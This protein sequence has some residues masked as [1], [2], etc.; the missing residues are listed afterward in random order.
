LLDWDNYSISGTEGENAYGG[1]NFFL[2]N[3][4]GANSPITGVGRSDFVAYL[5]PGCVL[6]DAWN[7]GYG[8][9]VSG[10]DSTVDAQNDFRVRFRIFDVAGGGY[11]AE[12]DSGQVCWSH[13]TLERFDVNDMVTVSTPYERTTLPDATSATP[14][15]A[16]ANDGFNARSVLSATTV[17]YGD[18]MELTPTAAGGWGL[19]VVQVRPGQPDT[20]LGGNDINTDAYPLVWNDDETLLVRWTLSAPDASHVDNPPEELRYGFEVPTNE[21]ISLTFITPNLSYPKGANPAD[22]IPAGPAMPK[23][24]PEDFIELMYTHSATTTTD[25]TDAARVRPRLDL[26]CADQPYNLNNNLTVTDGID[27]HAVKVDVVSFN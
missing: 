23:V 5:T 12:A 13:F 11:N 25:I 22:I 24:T 27:I 10:F 19:E 21:L 16:A 6:A 17:T 4:G 7:N 9:R 2:D 8:T 3:T 14:E 15:T 26:I 18:T 20:G 1:V